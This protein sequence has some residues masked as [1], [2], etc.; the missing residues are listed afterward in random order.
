MITHQEAE[1]SRDIQ[2]NL[3][4]TSQEITYIVNGDP[5]DIADEYAVTEYLLNNLNPFENGLPFSE[6]TEVE[7]VS[8]I[9]YKARVTYISPTFNDSEEGEEE[10][11]LP[12]ISLDTTG[13]STNVDYGLSVAEKKG[14]PSDKI[15]A[16][17]N[18]D[19]ETFNG[20][21]ITTPAMKFSQR[22]I[23]PANQFTPAFRLQVYR[24]TGKINQDEFAG[25]AEGDVLFLGATA[26]EV[27]N[28]VTFEKDWE[29][30]YNFSAIETRTNIKIGD[31]VID[32]K[33]GY[34]YLWTQFEKR[35]DQGQFKL[36]PFPIASYVVDVYE[37]ADF[38][39]LGI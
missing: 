31:Y 21:D 4:G 9:F 7:R 25:F 17:L 24:L 20:I 5:G 8:D 22:Q 29:V 34:Q 39:L 33:E 3:T 16:G 36:V 30:T 32:K 14:N 12:I 10:E 15:G 13:G 18:W 35:E 27:V 6:I 28:T 38:A 23:I 37:K 2:R 11:D 1:E 19:G 26:T